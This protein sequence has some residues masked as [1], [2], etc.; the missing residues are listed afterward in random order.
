MDLPFNRQIGLLSK[1][2]VHGPPLQQT[3]RPSIKDKGSWTSP[4]TEQLFQRCKQTNSGSFKMLP[5]I[6]LLTNHIYLKSYKQDLAFL[7]RL[8]CHK[9]QP[10]SQPTKT[11]ELIYSALPVISLPRQKGPN[12]RATPQRHSASLSIL[13]KT[14]FTT[15]FSIFF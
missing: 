15:N 14:L 1:I 5:T 6:S 4:P 12:S 10:T 2:K 8:N 7:P 9:I 3:N 11:C 13:F